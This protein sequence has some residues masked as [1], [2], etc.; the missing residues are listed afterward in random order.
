MFVIRSVQVRSVRCAP[1]PE[2]HARNSMC[3]R[4]NASDVI[5]KRSATP[6][7]DPLFPG[8]FIR[9]EQA[10]QSTSLHGYDNLVA[11]ERPPWRAPPGPALSREIWTNH[12]ILATGVRWRW[13]ERSRPSPSSE[14]FWGYAPFRSN[15]IT[16]WAP[17]IVT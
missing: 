4:V 6:L 15:N 16:G 2:Q 5:Q 8:G 9:E 1:K 3:E 17:S 10:C 7:D 11:L 12:P 14:F 13:V